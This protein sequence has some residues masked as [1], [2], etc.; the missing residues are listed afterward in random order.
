MVS[1]TAFSVPEEFEAFEDESEL[2]IVHM[3]VH[4]STCTTLQRVYMHTEVNV[5]Y[6]PHVHIHVP[7]TDLDM[8]HDR[9]VWFGQKRDLNAGDAMHPVFMRPGSPG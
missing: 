8:V 5:S 9:T 7:S 4:V 3:C 2:N 1:I 6:K